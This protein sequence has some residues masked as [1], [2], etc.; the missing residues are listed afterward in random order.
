MIL[1]QIIPLYISPTPCAATVKA[2]LKAW[3]IPSIK[4]NP[5]AKRGGGHVFYSAAAVEKRLHT[6]ERGQ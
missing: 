1:L 3:K 2:W 5:A 6:M 4:A